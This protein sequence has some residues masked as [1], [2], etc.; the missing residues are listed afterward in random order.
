MD[1]IAVVA[2]LLFATPVLA[3]DVR[4]TTFEPSVT[5]TLNGQQ[6]TVARD[7]DLERELTGPLARTAH[8]CPPDCILPQDLA[9]GV[10]TVA[11][12]ELLE[13]METEAQGGTGLLV[14]ARLPDGL[15]GGTIPGA[16]V[17]PHVTLSPDN[18]FRRDIL[19]ALGAR[20]DGEDLNFD[21]A[22]TLMIYAGGPWDSAGKDVIDHLL[23]AGY[24]PEKLLFY[25]GGMQSWSLLGLTT[26]SPSTPG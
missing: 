25:R 26:V 7:S 2:A 23:S 13:F 19:L 3:E 24:P 21:S 18:R 17:I 10:R 22:L 20:A 16:V 4:I 8:P 11:E 1:R 14:D 6:F 12:L 5:Y 9:E 15:S